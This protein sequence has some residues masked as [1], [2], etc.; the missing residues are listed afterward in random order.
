M[1][2]PLHY[3]LAV[4]LTSMF[5]PSDLAWLA[6]LEADVLAALRLCSSDLISLLGADG[7]VGICLRI[8][9]FDKE[10]F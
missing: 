9:L 4:G 6:K 10:T 2:F 8:R 3:T 7:Q 5:P 1:I